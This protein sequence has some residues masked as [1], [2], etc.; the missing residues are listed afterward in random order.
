[1]SYYYSNN[2]AEQDPLLPND[3]GAPEILGSRPQSINYEEETEVSEEDEKPQ[4]QLFSDALPLIFSI[5]ILVILAFTFLSEDTNGSQRPEPKTIEQRVN[6]ILTDTPLIGM[7][8]KLY[9]TLIL[10]TSKM[11]TMILLY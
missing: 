1:M 5:C 6:R 10:R 3:K 9:D 4:R 2:A 8:L 11:A 7:F